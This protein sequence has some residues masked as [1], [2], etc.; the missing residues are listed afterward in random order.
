MN[1]VRRNILARLAS[2]VIQGLSDAA[3]VLL[4]GISIPNPPYPT[5]SQERSRQ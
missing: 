4:P 1:P 3:G 2:R 5:A